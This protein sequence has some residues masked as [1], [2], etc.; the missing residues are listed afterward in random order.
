MK[1]WFNNNAIHLAIIGSFIAITFISFPPAWQRQRLYQ[2]DVLHARAGRQEILNINARDGDMPLW[3]NSMF[4]GM[5]SYQVLIELPSN[6]T[7]YLIRGFKGVFPHPIDVVLLYL[8]GAYLL[9]NVLR[10]KPLLA[11]VGALAFAFSS[12]N[13]IYIEAGHAN[14]TYALA[15]MAPILAGMLLAF[16]GKYLWGAVLLALAMALEIR[17]NHIQVTY[18]LFLAALILVGIEAYGAIREKRWL[19]FAKAIA[20][21]GG[22]VVVA[23]AVN[24]SLLWPTYEYSKETLRGASNLKTENAQRADNGV[25]REYAYQWSQGVGESLTFLIP[26]A[27]GGGMSTRLDG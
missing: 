4:S 26:N 13:F 10:V 17:V 15:F 14:K 7:T 18:Y 16:R 21:Q 1:T 20:F 9:F 8:I 25:S 2:P 22:A 27:Y 11:A 12:Y 3:T 6:I 24:T 5:P 19:I 23:I